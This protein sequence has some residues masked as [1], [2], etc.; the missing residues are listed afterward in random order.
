MGAMCRCTGHSARA[1]IAAPD[2]PARERKGMVSGGFKDKEDRSCQAQPKA[3]RP[4]PRQPV[5]HHPIPSQPYSPLSYCV[6]MPS[7][8]SGPVNVVV[9]PSQAVVAP[10]AGAVVALEGSPP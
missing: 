2:S 4:N 3:T 7:D 10:R 9:H 6:E 1:V 5:P 8:G